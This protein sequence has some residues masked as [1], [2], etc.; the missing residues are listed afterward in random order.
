MI[1]SIIIIIS[2]TGFILVLLNDIYLVSVGI[3]IGIIAT[4]FLIISK[5]TNIITKVSTLILSSL[6]IILGILWIFHKVLKVF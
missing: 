1:D 6:T 2:T 3:T 4:V 5:D